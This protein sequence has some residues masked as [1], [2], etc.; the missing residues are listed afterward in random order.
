MHPLNTFPALLDFI[1]LSPFI[2]RV[3]VGFFIIAIGKER[4]KKNLSSLSIVYY[5]CGIMLIL[6]FYTQIS[7][8]LGGVLLKFDFYL[9][10]WK[11]R[12]T[13]P[14]PRYFYFLYTIATMALISL[15][16]S[17]A[18]FLAFDMPF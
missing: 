5:V 9:E 8:I 12:K 15:L 11:S 7:S 18:G 2:I 4:S 14:V 6:G 3:V 1:R 16:F 10:Y 17:G 13:V